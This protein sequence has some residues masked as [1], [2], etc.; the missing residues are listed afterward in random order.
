MHRVNRAALGVDVGEL[1]QGSLLK[2]SEELVCCGEIVDG[3]LL[4]PLY[5][6][7]ADISPLIARFPQGFMLYLPRSSKRQQC[8]SRSTRNMILVCYSFR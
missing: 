7:D 8:P 4:H 6:D 3:I 1:R 2:I 5:Y